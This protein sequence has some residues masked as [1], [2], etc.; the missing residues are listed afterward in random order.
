MLRFVLHAVWG[1]WQRFLGRKHEV[2]L[3]ES[4]LGAEEGEVAWV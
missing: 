1:L 2:S 4:L 3:E